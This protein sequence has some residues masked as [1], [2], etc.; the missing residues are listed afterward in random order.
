MDASIFIKRRDRRKVRGYYI[1]HVLQQQFGLG[2]EHFAQNIGRNYGRLDAAA[3]EE[4]ERAGSV[5]RVAVAGQA[6]FDAVGK[7]IEA[8]NRDG[9][10]QLFLVL[11]VDIDGP[12]AQFRRIGNIVHRRL[13][14]PLLLEL[15]FC[16]IDDLVYSLLLF[17]KTPF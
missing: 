8:F 3:D 2:A 6:S 7:R 15:F 5:H 16:G 9:E 4:E 17:P 12:S 1:E 11:E 13:G 10:Q 14:E